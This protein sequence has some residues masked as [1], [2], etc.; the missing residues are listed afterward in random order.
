MGVRVTPSCDSINT[1][2]ICNAPNIQQTPDVAFGD[3]NYMVIW[4]D[5]RA[6][7]IYRIFAARVTPAG[8]VLDPTGFQV[9]PSNTLYHYYPSIAFNG[10]RFFVV[11]TYGS[12]P[13]DIMGRFINTDGTLGDTVC[14]LK[15][16]NPVYNTRMAFDGTNFLVVW[17]EFTGSV[18]DL[19][20]LVVSGGTGA[21]IGASFTVASNVY[22]DNSLGLCYDAP[23]YEITYS[24]LQG[25]TNQIF[26]RFYDTSGQ[27]A[28]TAFQI[29]NSAYNCYQCDVIPGTGGHFL[30]IWAEAQST[31]D[32]YGNA[33][34]QTGIT[35]GG[36]RKTGNPNMG[37]TIFANATRLPYAGRG[38]AIVYSVDGRKMGTGENGSFDCS[39]LQSGVYFLVTEGGE[40]VQKVILTR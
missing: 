12:S 1:V 3:S 39:R 27:P 15:P 16:G 4:S 17:V 5:G 26:G 24:T 13:Y 36:M 6:G 21:P 33:D 23:Y 7:S 30:N 11:W 14:M 9:G 2:V 29:S 25:S 34:I 38:R 31:Y 10:T 40:T 28:G 19:K 8:S 18:F 20:G 32:I 37:P 22:Y 35:D